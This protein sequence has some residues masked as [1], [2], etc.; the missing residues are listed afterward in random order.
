MGRSADFTSPM[1]AREVVIPWV[2]RALT[3]EVGPIP[4][5]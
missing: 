4:D 5:R 3:G 2:V 1:I